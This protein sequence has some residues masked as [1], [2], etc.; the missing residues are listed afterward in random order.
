MI[1]QTVWWVRKRANHIQNIS[2]VNIM[3]H[4]L[5][6][7]M[8]ILIW[9]RYQQTDWMLNSLAFLMRPSTVWRRCYTRW[10]T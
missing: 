2:T 3:E 4:Q 1:G 9:G 6:I 5:M 7:S 8:L 10:L